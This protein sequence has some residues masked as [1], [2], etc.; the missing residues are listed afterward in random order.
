MAGSARHQEGTSLVPGLL[1]SKDQAAYGNRAP[2]TSNT[3]LS[4]ATRPTRE[5]EPLLVGL[6]RRSRP[7]GRMPTGTQ[8][9]Q[10]RSAGGLQPAWRAS[11]HPLTEEAWRD[12]DQ[13]RQPVAPLQGGL[14]LSTTDPVTDPS[15]GSSLATT[16]GMHAREYVTS[17]STARRWS[18]T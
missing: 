16:K 7:G 14:W 10:A 17:R 6:D 2:G 1:E 9:V 11:G 12:P 15:R 8:E 13:V 18:G 3:L 5:A 4:G